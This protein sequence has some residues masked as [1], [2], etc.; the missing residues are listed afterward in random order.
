MF[1]ADSRHVAYVVSDVGGKMLVV[2]GERVG[3]PSSAGTDFVAEL[4]F[5]PNNR[6]VGYVGITGGSWYERGLTR[7]AKRR[8]YMTGNQGSITTRCAFRNYTSP[9]TAVTSFT[10]FINCRRA[11]RTSRLS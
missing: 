9:L 8:V 11:R 1:S 7:R 2:D 5:A 6:T 4:T 10:R 3:K